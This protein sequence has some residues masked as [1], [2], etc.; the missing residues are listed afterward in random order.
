MAIKCSAW[1]V[2]C[3][4]DART[5]LDFEHPCRHHSRTGRTQVEPRQFQDWSNPGSCT[6]DPCFY[7]AMNRFVVFRGNKVR[8]NG[9]AAN[10]CNVSKD[11]VCVVSLS[12]LLALLDVLPS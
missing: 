10:V 5:A 4:G 2:R 3:D 11:C 9:S 6:T 7:G 1:P 12:R 8:N